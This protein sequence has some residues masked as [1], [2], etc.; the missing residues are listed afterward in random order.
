M[1]L[2]PDSMHQFV[3]VFFFFFNYPFGL[4]ACLLQFIYR[5]NR[6]LHREDKWLYSSSCFQ[7]RGRCCSIWP[8]KGTGLRLSQRSFRKSSSRCVLVWMCVAGCRR[9]QAAQHCGAKCSTSCSTA[10]AL[11]APC[12]IQLHQPP[13]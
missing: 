8:D 1:N 9:H 2:W 10:R 5:I 7:D 4:L 11:K 13:C 3:C 12:I 6:K